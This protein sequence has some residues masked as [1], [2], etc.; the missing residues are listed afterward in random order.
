MD[1]RARRVVSRFNS[2]Y[3]YHGTDPE[4]LESILR[5]GLTPGSP[6]QFSQKLSLFD[7]GKHIFFASS[8]TYA[9]AYGDVLLRFPMPKDATSDLNTQRGP[10]PG[11]F[12]SRRRI[13]PKDIEIE[14]E[15]WD[16][17]WAPLSEAIASKVAASVVSLSPRL[18]EALEGHFEHNYPVT[19]KPLQELRALL[20]S[21]RS[22]AVREPR[23]A[24]VYRGLTVSKR[25]CSA[26]GIN[27]A[28]DGPQNV[29]F[30]LGTERKASSWTASQKVARGYFEL[31]EEV[32]HV[33]L[34]ASVAQNSGTFA[35]GPD[36]LYGV[37]GAR[38]RVDREML[39]LWPVL[40]SSATVL[41]S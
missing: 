15:K 11:Q 34:T 29:R 2:A 4:R 10:M 36:G 35:S 16:R 3:A 37:A 5:S 31:G 9:R 26:H 38:Q 12:V 19:G 40:V 27:V 22:S 41:R 6:S 30:T 1:D 33:L 20:T 8:P 13:A 18:I 25:W 14:I 23:V 28:G 7:K 39:A 21:G 24:V 32:V 17:G